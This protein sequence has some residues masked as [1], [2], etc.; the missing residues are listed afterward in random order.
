MPDSLRVF[1]LIKSL[2]RGGAEVLLLEGLRF[3]DRERFT[4]G[5]GYFLPWKNAMVASL[6][7][8]GG[9]VR[10]FAARNNLSILLSAQRVAKH[11]RTWR[12]DVLHCHLP[13][14][15]A[16]GRLAGR[17]AHIP[18]VY[19]EHNTLERYH[20]L[21][22]RL[23]LSTWRWQNRVIAV[24]RDVAA[25]L[26]RRAAPDVRVQLVPN[27]VDVERFGPA[28][29]DGASVRQKFGIPESA[30]VVGTV[31]VFRVQKRLDDWLETARLVRQHQ[32]D[33]HFL[34]VGDGPERDHLH[35]RASA[36]RL[37]D[38]VHFTGAH[39]DVRP[40]LA[41]MDVFLISSIF[42]GLPVALLEAMSMQRAI[43]STSVGGVP[44]VV[45]HGTNGLLV[46][47]GHPN[48]LAEA[49]LQLLTSHALRAECG[50]AARQT[51]IDY[52]S[53]QRMTR[54]LERTY[55]EVVQERR[56]GH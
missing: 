48:L 50:R 54:Q 2:G 29:V 3:A 12:A 44:E 15:G 11:L 6:A 49:V 36:L 30:P 18:V 24:S 28:L 4:Y 13:I 9:D 46:P 37:D 17:L 22:R 5:Y 56:S 34:L 55:V 40:F 45:R 27:G 42:E 32:P 35:A 51:V 19:T 23:N 43:V 16:V 25:S 7:E 20:Q 52:F 38:A 10:C 41:A 47:A 1:H 53:L 26:N 8:Q 14:A 31:A 21:T 33:V 39:T